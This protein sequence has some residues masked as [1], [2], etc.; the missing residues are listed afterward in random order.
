[1]VAS[2][3]ARALRVSSPRGAIM[4]NR[5]NGGLRDKRTAKRAESKVSRTR[6]CPRCLT[7]THGAE[8]ISYRGRMLCLFCIES[9]NNIW[10]L[11]IRN[12][13]LRARAHALQSDLRHL[14][15]QTVLL[16]REVR[17]VKQMDYRQR[18]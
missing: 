12:A 11:H 14:A 5:A 7:I 17:T 8:L 9:W 10:R 2:R 4:A 1:M 16:V 18:A 3:R 13:Q 15:R 6:L